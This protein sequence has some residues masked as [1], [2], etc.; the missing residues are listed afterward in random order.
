MF[1]QETS[2]VLVR[3]EPRYMAAESAPDEGRYFWAYTITIDNEGTETVRLRTRHWK[4][5]DQTGHVDHAARH[6]PSGHVNS[7]ISNPRT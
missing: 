7:G 4:I 6:V 5:T 2:D 3:V 1:E